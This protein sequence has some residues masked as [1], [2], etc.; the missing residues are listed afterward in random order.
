MMNVIVTG[1]TGFVG[2][3][4]V[5]LLLEKSFTILEIT[6]NIEKSISLYGD[7]TS[8]IEFDDLD[9]NFNK[10][11]IDFKPDIFLHLASYITPSD[12]YNS[13]DTLIGSNI[14][15]LSKILLNL[16]DSGL[17]SFI[18]TGTFAEFKNGDGV[19]SPA[20]Y[21]AAT[22]IASKYIVDYFSN[23]DNY[24]QVYV[25]PYT[26]YGGIDTNKKLIDFLFDSLNADEKV[27]LTPGNQVLDF[28]HVED[29]AE[30][31]LQVIQNID[32]IKNG[33]TYE[34]G[35]G[36]GTSVK[37]LASLIEDISGKK[38]NVEW[39]GREYRPNDVML[40]IA[41]VHALVDEI[42]WK[43]FIGLKEGIIKSYQK[44]L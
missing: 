40:A 9:V 11:I 27:K 6:R 23:K 8:K 7:K 41:D 3:H 1:S 10:K 31:Y 19:L 32:T 39:G 34:I 4:L 25:V 14:T 18:N 35:T 5:P 28:V 29:V 42:K 13:I 12:D 26:I 36:I 38:L 22:K 15:Y 24:K 37:D 20:Y 33:S 16:K 44:Y 2:R 43:P 21:Y 30:G 17:K